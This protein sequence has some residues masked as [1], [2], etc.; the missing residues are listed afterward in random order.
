MAKAN[1]YNKTKG[2]LALIGLI[3]FVS[4]SVYGMMYE[5]TG[6]PK[7]PENYGCGKHGKEGYATK[8]CGM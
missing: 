2:S 5:V 6:G 3:I 4:A 1:I 8:C 7:G